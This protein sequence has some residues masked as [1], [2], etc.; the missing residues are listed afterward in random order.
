MTLV[1]DAAWQPINIIPAERAF[2]MVFSQRA[3]AVESY[4][5][6]LCALFY[7]PSVII[8]KSYVRKNFVALYPT[9]ANILWRDSYTCQY[10]KKTGTSRTLTLDHIIPKSRGG[11]KGWLNIVTACERCN[12]RK[13]DK[14]PPEASMSLIREPFV[15]KFNIL[16]V[17]GLKETPE[18]W[19]KYL[20]E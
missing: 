20:G 1:L 9:R 19:K 7:Y 5:Q 15:P 2:G 17:L 10:C 14:T 12:Q 3:Q 13:G 4:S 18:P 16:R 6:K 11:D 8:C